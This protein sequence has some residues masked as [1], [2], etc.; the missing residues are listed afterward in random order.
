MRLACLH[1]KHATRKISS[2]QRQNEFSER[3][4]ISQ[5]VT[6]ALENGLPVV[7]LESTIVSHGMS[8]PENVETAMSVESILREK[9]VTPATISVM[10][11][12]IKIGMDTSE[13]EVLGKAGLDV[14]KTSRRDLAWVLATNKLG[15]TTVSATMLAA[16]YA[17]IPIFVTGGLGGVSRGGHDTMD[18][19]ADLHELART[20]VTV[21]SAGIKSILDITRSLEVLESLGVGVMTLQSEEF[22]AFY[23]RSS[24]ILSPLVVDSVQQAAAVIH[25]ARQLNLQNAHVL[26]VPIPEKDEADSTMIAQAIAQAVEAADNKR[27]GGR[28]YT[29][30]ILDRIKSITGGASQRVNI[31]LI[32]NNASVGADLALRLHGLESTP[33][34]KREPVSIVSKTY[35]MDIDE[36]P[37]G[38]PIA[39]WKP[40]EETVQVATPDDDR[41]RPLVVGAS[42]MDING[43]IDA[44]PYSPMET[45]SPGAIRYSSGGVGRNLA[46]IMHRLGKSPRF[47]S[48]LGDDLMGKELLIGLKEVGLDTRWIISSGGSTPVYNAIFYSDGNL[49]AAV[50]DMKLLDQVGDAICA[51]VEANLDKTTMLVFD[52]NISI[53]TMKRLIAM[54]NAK[55][56]P[57]LFEPTSVPKS[58]KVLSAVSA[59]KVDYITPNYSELLTMHKSAKDMGLVRPFKSLISTISVTDLDKIRSQIPMTQDPLLLD[60]L[61]DMV[62]IFPS[63]IM[64]KGKDGVILAQWNAPHGDHD[65][66]GC[67]CCLQLDGG[68]RLRIKHFGVS[69]VL[70]PAE[71]QNVTGAGDAL[72]G[73]VVSVLSRGKASRIDDGIVCG[74]KA[75]AMVMTSETT[76]NDAL[77]PAVLHECECLPGDDDY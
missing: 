60:A 20:P 62:H 19:S 69:R 36:A 55:Q 68:N 3:I 45:S 66:R 72:A 25:A 31:A 34:R 15:S 22:P 37:D 49:L 8:F 10:N 9:G 54:A 57:I 14:H 33:S 7:A 65:H 64:K 38:L 77:G 46:E 23:T 59:G 1:P 40:L 75:A 52:G 73:T 30:F 16:H 63:I 24:G 27:I 50:A 42:V 76:M 71:I 17:K 61:L 70:T 67:Q 29:P 74:I 56:V 21:V 28:D 41:K 12:K 32:K 47:I 43:K 35:L 26:A 5:E 4:E 11:G 51:N 48:A 13:L 18:V 53:D 44:S 58:I 39:P 6:E 2:F